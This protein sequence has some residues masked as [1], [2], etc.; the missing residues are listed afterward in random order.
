M[1]NPF[2]SLT[3]QDFYLQYG[4]TQSLTWS[5]VINKQTIN[6]STPLPIFLN[7]FQSKEEGEF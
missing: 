4:A 2:G 5:K 1:I 3:L 6:Y 7:L